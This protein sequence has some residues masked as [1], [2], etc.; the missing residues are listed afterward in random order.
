MVQGTF[1]IFKENLS[2]LE[3]KSFEIAK[4]FERFGKISRFLL[5]KLP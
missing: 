4:N 5:W 2:R 1:W 3:E